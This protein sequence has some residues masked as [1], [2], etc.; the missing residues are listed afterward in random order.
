[1]LTDYQGS[2]T[3]ADTT[4]ARVGSRNLLQAAP[5]ENARRPQPL[6]HTKPP[7][8]I[9]SLPNQNQDYKESKELRSK[10]ERGKDV[11]LYIPNQA[12]PLAYG[13]GFGQDP[14]RIS[15]CEDNSSSSDVTRGTPQA[16]SKGDFKRGS[17][18]FVTYNPPMRGKLMKSATTDA[19]PDGK[20]KDWSLVTW[21]KTKVRKGFHRFKGKL[22]RQKRPR[23][24]ID[25]NYIATIEF[26]CVVGG[27]EIIRLARAKLDTG[28]PY[29]IIS[30]NFVEKIGIP[31]D[32]FLEGP[33][34]IL[35]LPSGNSFTAIGTIVGRWT[36]KHTSSH[37]HSFDPKF[38]DGE[39]F[40]SEAHERFDIIIGS[41]TI[42]NERLLTYS[43]VA[44]TGF[45]EFDGFR[46]NPVSEKR[47]KVLSAVK[48]S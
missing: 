6:R 40:V 27:E 2:S 35:E 43:P 36:G 18:D 39:F 9:K 34:K 29:D 24:V 32:F 1:M 46:R 8:H 4:R 45:E 37:C 25:A 31:I 42:A 22:T 41:R 14:D 12:N 30:R 38:L 10:G 13:T 26:A 16:F 23:V 20:H 48:L 15:A 44:F 7:D 28:N 11:K 17:N 47:E 5:H 21:V 19:K 33:K 3:D